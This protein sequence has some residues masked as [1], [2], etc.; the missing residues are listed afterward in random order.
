VPKIIDGPKTN[1]IPEEWIKVHNGELNDFLLF[2]KFIWVIKS[3]SIK[4]SM[5]V[6][7]MK[8]IRNSYKIENMKRRDHLGEPGVRGIIILKWF[9][10]Q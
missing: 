3:R 5:H 9:L 4:W 2:T 7:N 6:T 1:E 10:Q 8:E